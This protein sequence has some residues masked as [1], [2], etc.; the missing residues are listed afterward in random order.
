MFTPARG[1]CSR[2]SSPDGDRWLSEVWQGEEIFLTWLEQEHQKWPEPAERL[3]PDVV[4]RG[5]DAALY[6][7][8][9]PA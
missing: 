5:V 4:F 3:W 9:G 6:E 7:L 8:G 2:S 1:Q